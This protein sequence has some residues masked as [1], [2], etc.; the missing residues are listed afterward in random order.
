[1][2]SSCEGVWLSGCG[3]DGSRGL[4]KQSGEGSLN[5]IVKA[6]RGIVGEVGLEPPV[7]PGD[8]VAHGISAVKNR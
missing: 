1:M 7:L 8:D 4:R 3:R 2:A 6:E 5:A